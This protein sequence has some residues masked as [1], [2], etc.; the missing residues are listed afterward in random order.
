MVKS[1]GVESD[2]G[3]AITFLKSHSQQIGMLLF[4]A[5]LF[6]LYYMIRQQV[7]E[8][9]EE[10]QQSNSTENVEESLM[11]KA[12]ECLRIAQQSEE[13]P[14][15]LKMVSTSLTY[16]HVLKMILKDVPGDR[17]TATQKL[18][19][20]AGK[21][22]EQLLGELRIAK[23]S[24][25]VQ[26]PVRSPVQSPVRSPKSASPMLSSED[27]EEEELDAVES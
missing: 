3:S 15:K 13:L 11:K 9:Q 23:P 12:Q 21:W 1:V 14:W 18:I 7:D 8:E 24:S 19:D 22:E 4:G 10:Q 6:G 16:L 5:S 17:L 27:E 26:S 25:P 2:P 20:Q